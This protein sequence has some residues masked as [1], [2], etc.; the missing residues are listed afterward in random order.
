EARELE[1]ALVC[2]AALVS[3]STGIVDSHALMLSLQGDA[4]NNGAQCVFHTPFRA[5]Q[6]LDSGE[7]LLQFDGADATELTASGV[8]NASGLSAPSVA[9]TPLGRPRQQAQAAS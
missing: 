1:P 2:D 3:P 4:E 6:V 5:G 8:I 7:F 9:R